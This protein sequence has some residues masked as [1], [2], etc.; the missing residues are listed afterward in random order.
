MAPWI[1]LCTSGRSFA[2]S[3]RPCETVRR[4]G[5]DIPCNQPNASDH[6]SGINSRRAGCEYRDLIGGPPRAA[7]SHGPGGWTSMRGCSGSESRASG[8]TS[9][10]TSSR[11]S[12]R[13][14]SPTPIEA[15]S[16]AENSTLVISETRIVAEKPNNHGPFRRSVMATPPI[17][18][19]SG[20]IVVMATP[21]IQSTSGAF[22]WCNYYLTGSDSSSI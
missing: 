15:R 14:R 17:R 19:A 11:R 13:C 10:A 18:S 21:P 3:S 2:A 4:A 9:A 20:R 7:R 12:G 8:L 1:L 16:R 22:Q 5:R 6:R